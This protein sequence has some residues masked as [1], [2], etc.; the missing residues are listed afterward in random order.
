MPATNPCLGCGFELDAEGY[1]VRMD[2]FEK[3]YPPYNGPSPLAGRYKYCDPTTGRSWDQPWNLPWG[4]LDEATAIVNLTPGTAWTLLY[5][6]AILYAPYRR[7][8]LG[9]WVEYRQGTA[10]GGEL[11]VLHNGYSVTPIYEVDCGSASVIPVDIGVSGPNMAPWISQWGPGQYNSDFSIYC[12]S[13]NAAPQNAT[14]VQFGFTVFD[15]GPAS[16]PYF[17]SVAGTQ[18]RFWPSPVPY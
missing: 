5:Q 8:R 17:A 12:R 3:A 7:M 18:Q 1:L 6:M 4:M 10:F 11:R 16:A 2:E 13:Y 15:D 9:G 14:F